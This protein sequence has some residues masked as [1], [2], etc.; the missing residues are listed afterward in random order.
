MMQIITEK[1]E[2][3]KVYWETNIEMTFIQN[4]KKSKELLC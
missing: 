4:K 1:R 3:I 2:H